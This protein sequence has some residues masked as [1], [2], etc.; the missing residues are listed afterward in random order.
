MLGSFMLFIWLCLVD[1]QNKDGRPAPAFN[2]HRYQSYAQKL[3][4]FLGLKEEMKFEI[5]T[6]V[7]GILSHNTGVKGHTDK[8]NDWDASYR[9][10]GTLSF[11]MKD[12][13]G[14]IYIFQVNSSML[15]LLFLNLTNIQTVDY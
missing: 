15:I 9:K 5:A 11:C 3:C 2:K 1:V 14:I 6:L 10:T 13:S 12:D 4:N 7:V 8:M